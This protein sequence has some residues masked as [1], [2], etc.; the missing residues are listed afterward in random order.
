MD[1]EDVVARVLG[2]ILAKLGYESEAVSDGT[3]ALDAFQQARVSGKPF[4]LV[5]M[6]L[7]IPGGMG[8]VEAIKEL[9][10]IDKTAKAI[11]SSGYS[12][13][14]AIVEAESH[15]FLAALSKPYTTEDVSEVLSKVLGK[16]SK[17]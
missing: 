11:V 7:T 15:G 10:T 6:D 4:D 16:T 12:D 17:K 14:A 2:R 8:G 1:D 5:I 9:H 13:D 3:A